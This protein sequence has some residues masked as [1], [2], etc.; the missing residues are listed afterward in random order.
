MFKSFSIIMALF[1]FNSAFAISSY[2][3]SINR[4]NKTF[5][6]MV[7]AY[8][9]GEYPMPVI[10]VSSQSKGN[11]KIEAYKSLR[12]LKEKVECTIS[13]GIYHPWSSDNKKTKTIFYSI[14][15][16]EDYAVIKKTSYEMFSMDEKTSTI[17]A[18]QTPLNPGDQIQDIYYAGEG[19]CSGTHV[20][21]VNKKRFAKEI[22][23]NCELVDDRKSFKRLT[24]AHKDDVIE[25]WLYV[26]CQEGYKA[27]ITDEALLKSPGAKEGTIKEYGTVGPK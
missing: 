11:T 18:V 3:I 21:K 1:A 16:Q 15:A 14:K 27:F 9:S 17:Q 19:T 5:K 8:W 26:S 23:F 4:D 2:K 25:Q 6:K 12:D 24:P 20:T 13:N 22:D 10:D 7:Y